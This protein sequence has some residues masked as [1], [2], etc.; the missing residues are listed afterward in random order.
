MKIAI[1]ADLHLRQDR[2][3]RLNTLRRLLESLSSEGI[4]HLI[5]AGDLFD[6]EVQNYSFFEGLVSS[7]DNIELFIIPGNHDPR[8]R[9]EHFLARNIKVLTDTELMSFE[10]VAFLFVPFVFGQTMDEALAEYFSE[11][12]R[13]KRWVLVSHGDYITGIKSPNPYEK[14]IYMPLSLRAIEKFSPERVILGHIHK[15]LYSG[16]LGRVCYPG[17]LCGLDINET[18]PRGYIVL[19]L[20]E[21]NLQWR[22]I[23]TDV[24]YYKGR[25]L[26]FPEDQRDDLI[27]RLHSLLSSFEV[28]TEDQ[29]VVLRLTLSGYCKDRTAVV[30]TIR[31]ALLERGIEIDEGRVFTEGLYH[32]SEDPFYEERVNLLRRFKDSISALGL[33]VFDGIEISHDELLE[34]AMN[35]IFQEK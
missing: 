18:G 7:Y 35:L 32:I 14:G 24:L 13:P 20:P 22:R 30:N 11:R 25:L 29:K 9:Q 10:E 27:K 4:G 5:I 21:I 23:K 34:E 19:E 1:T 28:E 3:E 2:P 6:K 26:V 31:E 33:N 15:P 16:E 12:E 17:S 8:L